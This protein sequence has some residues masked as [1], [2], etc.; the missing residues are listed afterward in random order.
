[1]HITSAPR[2]I[3]SL[4]ISLLITA[5]GYAQDEQ[6]YEQLYRQSITP[7]IEVNMS[8][9]L[10]GKGYSTLHVRSRTQ[11]QVDAMVQCHMQSMALQHEQL[12]R[13]GYAVM[14]EGGNYAQVQ[15]AIQDELLN[16]SRK[17]NG[18]I[19]GQNQVAQLQ[20]QRCLTNA[21]WQHCQGR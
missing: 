18:A 14:A 20:Q 10:S 17:G 4:L 9:R 1:M 21:L 12:R 6:R 19:I 15:A 13:R 16:A 3:L 5:A 8:Q 2:K 11:Q 7:I